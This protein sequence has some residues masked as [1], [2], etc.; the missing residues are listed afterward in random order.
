MMDEAGRGEARRLDT[1]SEEVEQGRSL[2]HRAA[3]QLAKAG[4]STESVVTCGHPAD[5][6]CRLA[7]QKRV[8][9][10][11]LGST[12]R[13]ALTRFLLGSVSY[14]VVKH[15]LSAVLL[16]KRE[17]RPI[18][19]VMIAVDGSENSCRAVDFMRRF[20]LPPDVS[21]SAVHVLHVR[22]PFHGA[23]E[24]YHDVTEL[25]RAL[26]ELRAAAEKDGK[27][28]LKDVTSGLEASYRVETLLAEGPPASTLVDLAGSRDLDLLVVGNRGLTGVERFLMGSVSFQ[29]CLHAPSSVLVVR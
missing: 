29:A 4:V 19:R 2:A 23:A 7:E 10:V 12:G 14:Q 15:A 18:Q 26:E 9:L 22:P 20:P 1:E 5:E 3:Y 8:E 24:G 16:V 25:A 21:L 11:V 27:K 6:I 28:L 13:S 17:A